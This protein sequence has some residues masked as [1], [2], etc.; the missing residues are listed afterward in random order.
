MRAYNGAEILRE[1]IKRGVT[2]EESNSC[3]VA[4]LQWVC[5]DYVIP[6]KIF[7]QYED[8]FY[9]Q[10]YDGV[11]SRNTRI[12]MRNVL[13]SAGVSSLKGISNQRARNA[14]ECAKIL[15][16]AQ[17]GGRRIIIFTSEDH[18]VGLRPVSGGWRMG[19]SSTPIDS[20]IVLTSL[21]VFKYLYVPTKS[22]GKRRA[23]RK[24]PPNIISLNP[25]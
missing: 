12:I 5:N 7:E 24:L 4:A 22:T 10:D 20:S 21:Q 2:G 25:E 1:Q 19:G 17:E 8:A 13:K 16:K 14:H 9:V 3:F 18:V 23:T 15:N 11:N 6:D